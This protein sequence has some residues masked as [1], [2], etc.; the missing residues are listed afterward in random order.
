M[1]ELAFDI[2][3]ERSK[4]ETA[5]SN[6]VVL[7]RE[8]AGA[9]VMFRENIATR[10]GKLFKVEKNDEILVNAI[11]VIDDICIKSLHYTKKIINE[12]GIP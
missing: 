7:A 3:A 11:R 10:V 6:L 12:F 5:M 1:M 8:K 4:R 9:D 2:G